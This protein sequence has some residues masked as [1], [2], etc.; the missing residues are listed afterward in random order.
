MS[1]TLHPARSLADELRARSDAH[2]QELFTLRPDLLSPLPTDFSALAARASSS[3][4]IARVLDGC[5]TWEIQVLET[6]V[7]LSEP[8]TV[9]A[10]IEI[11]GQNGMAPYERFH[12]LALI[13][14][15][16]GQIRI[17]NAVRDALG[18]E[19]AGLG[20]V[21]LG[22][23]ACWRERIAQAPPAARAML[24]KL[25]WGPPRGAVSDVRRPTSTISWLL[26]NQ[27][28]TPVD[29]QTVA[30]PR[31]VAM[32]LRGNRVHKELRDTP[33]EYLAH[34][35]KPLAQKEIDSAAIGAALELLHH[36]EELMHF[37]ASEPAAAL[38][39]GGIGVREIKR[40]SD[41]LGLDDKYLTFIA[42]LAYITGLVA[43]HNDEEFLPTSAFDIWRN[44]PLE[45]RWREIAT[46]WLTTSRVAGL[47]GKSERGYIAPL[48]PEIDRT[49][50]AHIKR[51]ALTL[52]AK[53]APSPVDIAGLAERIKW[54]RP[55]K[56]L[57]SHHDFVHWIAREGQWLGFTGRNALTSYASA[58]L[59]DDANIGMEPLL[60][61]EI[62]HILIQADNTAIAPGPLQVDLAREMSLL[63][64]IES[65][66][67]AT[68]YRISE[69]SI[70]RALDNGRS[71]EDIR[72]FLS[73]ISKTPL[74]QPLQYMITDVGKRYGKLRVGISFSS[75]IRCEDSAQLVAILADKKV[76]H[77]Q[78]RQLSANV[79]MTEGD[80][81]EAIDALVEAGYFPALEDRDGSLIARKNDRARAKN[82]P[83]P[84]R[85][86]GDLTPPTAELITAALRALRAGDKATTHR[87]SGS[88]LS[89]T[90]SETMSTLSLAIKS[91][92]T[93]T[94]GYA[95]SDGG[96]TERIIEPIHLIAGVLMAYDHGSDEVLRFSVSRISGVSIVE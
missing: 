69:N 14:M 70:R 56:G 12:T 5:T 38:R 9:N 34:T 6:L 45:E 27:L 21:G 7:A 3:P 93:V 80:I 59:R 60:P 41:E 86:S 19:P 49:A 89:G 29:N 8:V 54:E 58:L 32:Y 37:W 23:P 77:L 26:E 62:D 51:L 35:G 22:D 25:T 76:A 87:K 43:L 82:K 94:I 39:S 65:K 2:L 4:S 84:P 52:Y 61:K 16:E 10:L 95:D 92:A 75:Y 71:S 42:E 40:A 11:A 63:A 74:P 55:R 79:L 53:V 17:L 64:N 88:I 15:D 1:K 18:P 20:P 85:I 68:V 50:I 67:G 72:A 66:G 13:Y 30:L 36:I 78:L 73:K 46:N 81:N 24:E 33:P 31:E 57:G 83:R 48:G 44:K 47:V 90:P 28:L 96:V 91:K